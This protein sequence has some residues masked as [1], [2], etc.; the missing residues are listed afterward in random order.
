MRL[1]PHANT[2]NCTFTK[3]QNDLVPIRQV[4]VESTENI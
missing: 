3:S 1:Q 2:E 4:I